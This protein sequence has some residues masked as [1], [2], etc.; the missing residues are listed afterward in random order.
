MEMFGSMRAIVFEN[1]GA[2]TAVMK[3]AS[4]SV[5]KP[6]ADEVLVKVKN[7]SINAADRHMVRANYFII[8][9]LL[10]FFSPG[11]R[12]LG[13]DLAGT[14]ARCGENVANFQVGDD[15][16]ADVRTSYGGGFAE[17][18]VVKAANLVKKPHEISFQQAAAV[19]I[20]GQ[21]A[22]MGITLC[23]IQ[24]GDKVLV[25][26][27]S[28]GVGSFGVQIAKAQGAHVTAMCSAVKAAAVK[29]WGADVVIDSA[30]TSVMQ[31]K[32]DEYDAVFDAAS[33]DDPNAFSATL[34]KT[35]RYVLVG[36]DFYNMLK[37][38][39][40]GR[41]YGRESQ[42]FTALTQE[43]SVNENIEKVLALIKKG[44]LAPAIQK[45]VPLQQVP[46]A[47]ESLEN[48]SVVGKIIID[49]KRE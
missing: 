17:Y 2:P 11:S 20:S 31:L 38:K 26:G 16:V 8:R 6:N 15:V 36:G 39:L 29:E 42:T 27:A 28:G 34:K 14:V 43:V 37:L 24:Q 35:G 46:E 1:Y 48:R 23:Q 19:P 47:I 21:A 7:C 30:Q 13:M 5:P 33:F 49:N 18:A 32:N 10:G 44:V 40:G 25:N 4:K 45:V 12:V 41:F 3:L 9:A 22:M